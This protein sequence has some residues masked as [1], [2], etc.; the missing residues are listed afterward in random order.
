MY[1]VRRRKIV[2]GDAPASPSAAPPAGGTKRGRKPK[3]SADG[4][5]PKRRGRKPAD[6]PPKKRGRPAKNLVDPA[7]PPP[8]SPPS[9]P[10]KPESDDEEERETEMDDSECE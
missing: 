9:P 2:S 8:P 4:E 3:D 1:N 6:G 5:P 7:P 10:T